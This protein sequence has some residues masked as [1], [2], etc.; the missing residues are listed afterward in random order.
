MSFCGWLV[1]VIIVVYG[2]VKMF[3]NNTVVSVEASSNVAYDKISLGTLERLH[4]HVK[5][6]LR[7]IVKSTNSSK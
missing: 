5:D 1:E 4:E 7:G 6:T 3:S 2:G